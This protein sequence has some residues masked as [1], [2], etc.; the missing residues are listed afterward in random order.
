MVELLVNC[1]FFLFD[2]FT[3]VVCNTDETISSS[4]DVCGY[5]FICQII[6]DSHVNFG[7]KIWLE[8][9]DSVLVNHSFSQST[10]WYVAN[11]L[12]HHIICT[13]I[14]QQRTAESHTVHTVR[15]FLFEGL[16]GSRIPESSSK[17]EIASCNFFHCQLHRQSPMPPNEVQQLN[18]KII[19]LIVTYQ[20]V[21]LERSRNRRMSAYAF[22]NQKYHKLYINGKWVDP[23]KGGTFST[24]NPATGIHDNLFKLWM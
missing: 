5:H 17:R 14:I 18:S 1:T 6:H 8:K 7:G 22:E 20:I 15:L 19:G 10:V 2:Y 13:T 12:C 3:V 24:I 11:F 21:I 16:I 9:Y 23:L 4:K